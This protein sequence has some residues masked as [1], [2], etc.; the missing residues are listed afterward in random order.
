MAQYDSIGTQ[1][2]IIKTTSFNKLERFNFRKHVEPFLQSPG[3]KLLDLACGTGFYSD[4]LLQWGAGLLVG[5]DISSAMVDAARAR[6][7]NTPY[8]DQAQ[9]VQGDGLI[10]QPYSSTGA[11]SF[12]VV[13]GAWFLNYA[14][15]SDQMVSMFQTISMN[16][17]PGGVFVGICPHPTNDLEPFA[18]GTNNSAWAKTGVHYKYGLELPGGVGYKLRVFGSSSS[19]SNPSNGSVEFEC[20]HLKKSSYEEAARL[21]G[22]KGKIEWQ[23]CTFLDQEW[24]KEVGLED[25]DDG[26]HSLQEYPLLSILLIWKE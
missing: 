8:K 6:I 4:L 10:P 15:S 21:G 23:T 12:D 5:M 18:R 11:E 9:F 22:M 20:Y 24:R 3:N 7:S 1:Y 16:L 26:W 25:D 2:D 19:S 14:S 17:K 13:T